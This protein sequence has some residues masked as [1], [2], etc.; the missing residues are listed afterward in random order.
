[1]DQLQPRIRSLII[2]A[3]FLSVA[4]DATAGAPAAPQGAGRNVAA[5]VQ[6]ALDRIS[7]Y[8]FG[9]G[10]EAL[11]ALRMI[12]QS[13]LELPDLRRQI[14]ERMI[15]FLG[16]DGSFAG[17]QFVCEQ[18][19][20]IGS[21][22]AVPVLRQLLLEEETAD[23]ALYALQ[24]IPDPA[25]DA[26]LRGSLAI[27]GPEVR[28]AIINSVGERGDRGAVADLGA[29]IYDTDPQTARS[30][31]AALGK[32]ADINA[33]TALEAARS[34]TSG[35][36]RG[37][38]LDAYL[39]CADELLAEGNATGAAA[40]Y[41]DLY[42]H[43]D[44]TNIRAAALRGLVL[45]DEDSAVATIL[46][47]LKRDNRSLQAVA[48]G[49]LRELP[50]T[51]DLGIIIAEVANL[52][53]AAQIQLL[54]ALAERTEDAAYPVVMNGM[55]HYDEAVRVA[56]ISALATLGSAADVALL[57][58][59]A[60][61]G[62]SIADQEAA[63]QTLGFLAGTSVD[64][65]IIAQIP[66]VEPA[67]RAELVRALGRR[68]ATEATDLL[69]ETAVDPETAVRRESLKALAIVAGPEL[70]D[71]LIALLIAEPDS[72]TRNEAERT[73]VLVSQKNT[74][75]SR[76]SAPVLAV[77]PSVEIGGARNSLLEVLG[78]IG[79]P[80]ALPA[81]RAELES[82]DAGSQ[83]AAIVALSSWPDADPAEDLRD[84][85][86]TSRDRVVRIL[87]LRGYITLL[88]IRSDRPVQQ[89][90][91]LFTSAM[92][93]ATQTTE[94]TMVL[95]GFGELRGPEA[96]NATVRYLDDPSIQREAE[97]AILRLLGRIR[98][99]DEERILQMLDDG[100]RESLH[101]VLE[102]SNDPELREVAA[103]V[104]AK[105]GRSEGPRYS[106]D[107]P[108]TATSM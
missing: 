65:A 48:A 29:L 1:M 69:L 47:S 63:R 81:I 85:A 28:V 41:R 4:A 5:A 102:V 108:Y 82:G 66:R 67:L 73:V 93:L 59:L 2:L 40:I 18:L 94:K 3:V 88:R 9:D 92:A 43:E 35:E 16:S 83:R 64:Q 100:L 98:R 27:A 10:R 25:V 84:V 51:L 39:R 46:S 77:L 104:L 22:A 20:I 61:S 12:V 58:Q 44:A 75:T 99:A 45:T 15:A 53:P 54:S 21:S 90:I 11:S 30:A 37:L 105:G 70:I 79:D 96:L 26:A 32:I 23:I 97:A 36:L 101:R 106:S 50:E 86:A 76:P 87:A 31:V 71:E 56:A 34:R 95:A 60:A 74:G 17:K 7:E 68:G 78:R 24:R 52:S 33:A 80:S 19:S 8:E 103:E 14:E 89:S 55:Q 38:V 13:T 49:L 6:S 107:F 42:D 91:D 62:Q 72:G 57:T